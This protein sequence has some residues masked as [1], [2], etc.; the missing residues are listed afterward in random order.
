MPRLPAPG[1]TVDRYVVEGVL[2]EGGI[3]TVFRV[4]HRSLGTL[5][6]LKVLRHDVGSLRARMLEEGRLQAALRHPNIVPVTDVLDVDGRPALLAEFVAGGSLRAT[7]ARGPLPRPQAERLFRGILEGVRHAHAEGMVHR[8]LK[9]ENVLL[10]EAVPRI[11]DFGVAKYLVDPQ[12]RARLTRMSEVF[13]APGYSAPE[14]ARG[15]GKV[16]QRADLFS[17][18]AILYELVCSERAFPRADFLAA[19]NMAARGEYR[20]PT[21]LPERL[22]RAIDGCLQ[23]DPEARIA[24]CDAIFALLDGVEARPAEPAALLATASA[25]PLPAA[26]TGVRGLVV[27]GTGLGHCVEVV[28]ELVPGREGCWTPQ[29]VAPEA[30]IAAE[31]AATAVFGGAAVGVRWQIRARGFRLEGASLGLPLAVA[32]R[33]RQLGRE[34]PEGWAFTGA[35]DLDGRVGAV[36]GLPAKLRAA[37][38]LAHVAIPAVSAAG[39]NA[40]PGVELVAVRRLADLEARIFA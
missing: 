21:G 31:L 19:A 1:D 34:I 36:A 18:G 33:A 10:D 2:G 6:A 7:L 11:T 3:A 23:P 30:A 25:E 37:A 38:G 8:D 4:R 9:P 15:S 26:R 40:P 24:S 20:R 29:A 35:V 39:L 12:G 13:G 32:M 14:Q 27:D 28:V 16:D 22:V 17:L 5:H